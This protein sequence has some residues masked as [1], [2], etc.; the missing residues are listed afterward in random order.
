MNSPD[1]WQ[2][3]KGLCPDHRGYACCFCASLNPMVGEYL[4][5]PSTACTHN[6]RYRHEQKAKTRAR[7]GEFRR[8]RPNKKSLVSLL[9]SFSVEAEIWVQVA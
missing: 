7:P 8:L 4:E 6:H 2:L 1:C 5:I 3:G 9:I